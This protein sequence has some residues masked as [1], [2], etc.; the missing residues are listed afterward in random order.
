M[1]KSLEEKRIETIY[2]I[3]ETA[4]LAPEATETLVIEDTDGYIWGRLMSVGGAGPLQ[5][6]LVEGK[7]TKEGTL[8]Y[9]LYENQPASP[10]Q[11]PALNMLQIN[12]TVLEI[13][14]KN[15]HTSAQTI[16]IAGILCP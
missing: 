13:T 16:S 14:V 6:S 8:K 3:W 4:L 12:S 5:Y 1:V 2:I 10:G 7:L 11:W 9:K 15:K